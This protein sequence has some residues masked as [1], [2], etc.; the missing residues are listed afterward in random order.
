MNYG[1]IRRHDVANGTGI[2]TVIFVTG[3]TFNCKNCFNQ[4][5]QDFNAGK[6]WT[7]AETAQVIEYLKESETDGLTILGGE[8]MLNVPELTEIVKK[9]KQEVDKGIWIFSGFKYEQIIKNKQRKELLELCDV[10]VDGLFVEELKD[11]TLKFKGS[12]NQ[13]T[14]DIQ[15]SLKQNK[16]IEKEL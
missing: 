3:C 6:K 10:L 1:Q 13:R 2:R 11:L 8:P 9:I 7:K 15:K 16:I 4:E 5:Y 14:I 12:S